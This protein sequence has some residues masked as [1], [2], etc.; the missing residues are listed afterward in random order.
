MDKA[1]Q[2]KQMRRMND[3]ETRKKVS[4]SKLG[5]KRIYREDGSHYY[6][7]KT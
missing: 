3:P 5:R 7:R 6:E 2:F 4:E 1:E